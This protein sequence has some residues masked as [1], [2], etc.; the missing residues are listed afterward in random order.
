M[1]PDRPER[2]GCV[3]GGVLRGVGR[4]PRG[5]R[6]VRLGRALGRGPRRDANLGGASWR[7]GRDREKLFACRGRCLLREDEQVETDRAVETFRIL[8]RAKTMEAEA[9]ARAREG[10]RCSADFERVE[11]DD[12]IVVDEIVADAVEGE[13]EGD[14]EIVADDQRLDAVIP[15]SSF[16]RD[17]GGG[18]VS[19]STPAPPGER[20]GVEC[21][22]LPERC[23]RHPKPGRSAS[24]S[25][26]F[27]APREDPWIREKSSRRARTLAIAKMP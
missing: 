7:P 9:S 22:P 2:A 5:P 21:L 19:I 18:T 26:A 10:A 16:R 25:G 24:T 12:E 3:G 6:G 20:R 4:G 13:A 14:D 17:C 8:P 11:G 27:T 1:D 23:K 15:S